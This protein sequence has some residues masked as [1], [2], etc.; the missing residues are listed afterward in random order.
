MLT[1]IIAHSDT[2]CNFLIP[3]LANFSLEQ[4]RHALNVLEALIVCP[5][6][7]KTLAALTGL[8]PCE[9]AD[10][11]ALADFFRQS[12][13]EADTL[14][15]KF[16]LFP[17]QTVVTI[18]QRT[19]W[20][21]LFLSVD[22]ALCPKDAATH[23][24]ETVTYQYHHARPR[25]QKGQCPNAS[26][27]V[28]VHLQ[29]GSLQ[30]PPWRLSLKR[31]QV[32]RLN[33]ERQ[34]QQLPLLTYRPLRLLVEEM[35]GEVAA[36]LPKGCRVSGLFDAWYDSH[37]LEKFIRAQGGHFIC[38][39]RSNRVVADR[40]LSQWWTHRGHQRLEK[41]QVRTPSRRPTYLTRHGGGC[42]RHCPQAVVAI[43]S[44]RDRRDSHPAYFLGSDRA[45]SVR[46][47]L[48]YYDD[49]WQAEVDNWYL[50]E[51]LGLADDRLQS[52]DAILRWHTLGLGAYAFLQDRR[53]EP[54]L[55]DPRA[56]LRSLPEVIAPHQRWHAAQ[57]VCHIAALVR[58][59]ASDAELIAALL[60]T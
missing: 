28:T 10:L 25:R 44:K 34:Q 49:R 23:A 52:L 24:P 30:F 21:L 41:V 31:D 12:P 9:H 60:P 13:W 35:R 2:L 55:R 7:H 51:R 27:Y 19:G 36:H 33:R 48:N 3:L 47:I 38:A 39:P 50:K 54:L 20:R 42:L 57:T 43:L 32:K 37:Q 26:R 11:F 4:Q 18:Q 8:L 15:H 17:L 40:A 59:G 56:T 53:G 1:W 45:L 5:A 29:L 14:R 58:E 6:K 16:P 46:G 22:D